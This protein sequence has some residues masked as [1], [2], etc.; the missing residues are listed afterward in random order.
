MA[1]KTDISWTEATWNPITGCAI[2]SPGCTNCYAMKLAGT[3]LKNHPSRKGLTVTSKAGP[4][5]TGETRFNEQWLDQPIRWRREREIF[6]V[7]HGDLFYE[8]VPRDWIRKIWAVMAGAPHHR[9]QVL[10]KRAERMR[11]ILSDPAFYAD[12][13]HFLANNGLDLGVRAEDLDAAYHSLA[14]DRPLPHVYI[15]V[16]TEDQDRA[17]ERVPHLMQTPAAVRWV[18]AEPLLGPINFENLGDVTFSLSGFTGKG[19]HLLGDRAN[20]LGVI[21]AIVTGGESQRGS[22][23]MHPQWAEDIR[24]QC[25]RGGAI[26]HHKQ[27][28]DWEA[29]GSRYGLPVQEVE[30]EQF[31]RVGTD[32]TGRELFGKTYDDR[33]GPRH[34]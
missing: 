34:A 15:G 12:A 21:D 18:S 24:R 19:E 26:F 14:A 28:G 29:A 3:R 25:E 31:I 9:F 4:V 33:I 13:R 1:D 8:K 7:A 22:R 16:S 27:N 23:P 6:V 11:E 17:N 20:T 32:E 2:V 30:G 5:W 10:T